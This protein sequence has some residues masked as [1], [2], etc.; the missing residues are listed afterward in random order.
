MSLAS[1]VGAALVVTVM[2]ILT[3][4]VIF[5]GVGVAIAR[6]SG[7]SAVLGFALG[8]VLGPIGWLITWLVARQTGSDDLGELF[9]PALEQQNTPLSGSDSILEEEDDWWTND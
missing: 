8:A 6:S 7:G 4:V 1:V 2:I 5:G 9:D 3:W